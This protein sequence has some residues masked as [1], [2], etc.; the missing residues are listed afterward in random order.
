METIVLGDNRGAGN[1]GEM[2]E[3]NNENGAGMEE[4]Q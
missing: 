2:E 1:G 3:N 4:E